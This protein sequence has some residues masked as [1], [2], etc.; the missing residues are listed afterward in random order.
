[1]L[2]IP[3]FVGWSSTIE[4]FIS[5]NLSP[6]STIPKQSCSLIFNLEAQKSLMK[7]PSLFRLTMPC[8]P[9]R[10]SPHLGQCPLHL[11]ISLWGFLSCPFQYVLLSFR[12]RLTLSLSPELPTMSSHSHLATWNPSIHISQRSLLI[13]RV[14]PFRA[15]G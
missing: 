5:P 7:H 11:G 1:M 2:W 3:F 4:A 15:R 9:H 13:H 6:P 10:I 8:P 14:T 12:Q